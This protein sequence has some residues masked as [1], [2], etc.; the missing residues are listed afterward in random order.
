MNYEEFGKEIL[1]KVYDK[2]KRECKDCLLINHKYK[3]SLEVL[4]VM[5]EICEGERIKNKQIA[6]LIALWHDLG[7]FEQ[8]LKYG[9]FIDFKS[10]DHAELS[11]KMLDNLG[12]W[13]K[14]PEKWEDTIKFAIQ[15]HN[16][17]RI[18]GGEGEKLLMAKLIRDADKVAN[19]LHYPPLPQKY[20]KKP[21][22]KHIVKSIIEGELINIKQ[23]ESEQDM[24]ALRISML[25]D[26]NFKTSWHILE[27]NHIIEKLIQNL[28]TDEE[29]K[30]KIMEKIMSEQPA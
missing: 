30:N 28:E 14:I 4:E 8:A 15:N 3:H 22:K 18:N 16:K 17:I 23:V 24:L 7:R 6:Y 2:Y 9:H 10:E 11:V 29:T 12:I 13:K 1:E 21:P 19:F 20:E 5:K 26:I 25:F 27:K